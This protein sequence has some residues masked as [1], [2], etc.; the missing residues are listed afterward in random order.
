MD[1]CSSGAVD[2]VVLGRGLPRCFLLAGHLGLL[3][4]DALGAVE[5]DLHHGVLHQRGEAEQQAGD[6]PDVDGFHVGHLGQLRGQRRALRGQGQH[7][8]DPC[9]QKGTGEG[10]G[11]RDVGQWDATGPMVLSSWIPDIR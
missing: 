11:D 3:R 8:Q 9:G 2:G 4:L 1:G 6:Q 5:H 10:T 7:G